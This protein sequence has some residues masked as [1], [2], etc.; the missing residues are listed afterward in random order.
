MFR[1]HN[2]RDG[3]FVDPK[4]SKANAATMHNDAAFKPPAVAGIAYATPLYL[5]AGVVPALNSG[6]STIFV[7]TEKNNVYALDA[8]TGTQA[9]TVNLGAP[10]G[11][12]CGNGGKIS[13]QGVTG[14]PAIDLSTSVIVMDSAQ[15]GGTT[16]D[17][18]MVGLDLVTGMT[19]WKTPLNGTKDK[20]GHTFDA[21]LHVERPAVL[22]ANNFAYV[23]FAGNIG[24][25]GGYGGWVIGV[26][27]DG[28]ATKTV[29]WRAD[30][31]MSGVWG[32]GGASTDGTSIFVA[33][34]NGPRG[35][36]SWGENESVLRLGYD[37]S[38]D[39]TN[40]NNYWAPSNWASLDSSDADIGGTNPLVVDTPGGQKLLVALGKDGNAYLIDRTNMGGMGNPVAKQQVSNG[41][42]S[43]AGAWA[44]VGG[45]TY[46]VANNNWTGANGC[47]MGGGDLFAFTID[48]SNK[49]SEVWCGNSGGHSQPIITATDSMGTDAIVW[50]GG[51][52]DTAGGGGAGDGKLHA[53]DL[54]MGMEIANMASIPNMT[55]LSSS[56]IAANGHIYAAGSKGQ[57]YA[58]TP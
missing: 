40:N 28:D 10:G 2:N 17:H 48:S 27:L 52:N 30:A 4:L 50:V 14:T 29:A 15:G 13:P 46:V 22:I 35:G 56:L 45:T 42:I 3:F 16:S 21:S 41:A 7:A 23:G 31:N 54:A 33:T 6:K 9:W 51:G 18:V 32:P 20:A 49:I 58:V 37:L 5:D 12:S 19:K 43:G 26:S 11:P 36:G 55:C 34:G 44:N 47:A 25:C 8:N 53:F 1:N 57:V 24:D 38:F 39:K